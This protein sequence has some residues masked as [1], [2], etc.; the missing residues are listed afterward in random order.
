[1]RFSKLTSVTQVT[2][3]VFPS[4]VFFEWNNLLGHDNDEN[5]AFACKVWAKRGFEDEGLAT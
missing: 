5:F 4:Q 2:L 1:M 3:V